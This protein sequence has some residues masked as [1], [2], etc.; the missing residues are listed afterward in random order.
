[1]RALPVRTAARSALESILGYAES[2]R[3]GAG[4]LRPAGLPS[5]HSADGVRVPAAD[6]PLLLG[7]AVELLDEP[8]LGVL[9]ASMA[10]PRRHGLLAYLAST[11]DTLETAW[12]QSCRFIGLWNEGMEL[13]VLR[14][15]DEIAI[16]LRPDVAAQGD[17]LRQL[18]GLASM[19]LVRASRE[20]SGGTTKPLR[21][22]LACPA[23]PQASAWSEAYSA[24]VI[25]SAPSSRI[26]FSSGDAALPVISAD[27]VLAGILTGH[28]A[29][30]LAQ[31]GGPGGWSGR[32]REALV[33][34]IGKGACDLSAVA[35][36]L[37]VSDRTL[38]RRL[39][40]EANS[41]ERI[42]DE[43]RRGLALAYLRDRRL[44]IAEVA[45]LLDYVELSAF[46]RA[47]KRWTG[48]TPAEFRRALPG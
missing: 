44:G 31:F 48:S 28:A 6:V 17:G 7:R 27:S 24:P 46:Y 42:V 21:V 8:R 29:A 14:F 32:V 30:A 19:T 37:R 1:M 45:W 15:G 23:P 22:E 5:L 13:Q 3:P 36:K 12:R 25:F 43:A 34:G 33:H 40:E 38:Q 39:K 16:T 41:F 47:F 18:L 10:D 9:L 2:V 26:V 11:S 35:A 20:F 4:A